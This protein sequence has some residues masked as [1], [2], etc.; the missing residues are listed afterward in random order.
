M[1]DHNSII[2]FLEMVEAEIPHE[3]TSG[4]SNFSRRAYYTTQVKLGTRPGQAFMNALRGTPYYDQL[5]GGIHD[6]F[7]DFGFAWVQQALDF[8]TT[9]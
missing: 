6:P 5:V 2:E 8:L 4:I 7:Y 9:K 3:E 1:L